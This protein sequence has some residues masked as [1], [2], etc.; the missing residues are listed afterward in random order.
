MI[1]LSWYTEVGTGSCSSGYD[2]VQWKC[3]DILPNARKAG[4]NVLEMFLQVYLGM[5]IKCNCLMPVLAAL[6]SHK[7]L[8]MK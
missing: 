6:L 2:L 5:L 4:K 7:M 1:L 3:F 8:S